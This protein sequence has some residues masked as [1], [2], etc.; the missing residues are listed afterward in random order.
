MVVSTNAMEFSGFFFP[1]KSVDENI[2][3][4][5]LF[6]MTLGDGSVSDVRMSKRDKVHDMGQ[7]W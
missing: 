2:S 7:P 3:G 5:Q 1:R 6:R 4:G